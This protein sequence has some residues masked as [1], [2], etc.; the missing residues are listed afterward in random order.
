MNLNEAWEILAAETPPAQKQLSALRIVANVGIGVSAAVD[1]IGRRHLLLEVPSDE[2]LGDLTRIKGRRFSLGEIDQRHFSPGTKGVGLVLEDE[3]FRDLFAEL[4]RSVVSEVRGST[5]ARAAIPA[6]YNRVDRWRLFMERSR[7]KLSDAEVRGLIGEL[8]ILSRRVR[9][10]GGFAALESW[11][12]PSGSIRDFEAPDLSIEVKAYSGS[13]GGTVRI[14]DPLQ[15]VPDGTNTLLLA[16]VELVETSNDSD[17]LAAH[18]ERMS[19]LLAPSQVMQSRFDDMLA[20][21]GYVE[22]HSEYYQ[23]GYRV[24]EAKAFAVTSDFPRID[25]SM[26]SAAVRNVTFSML[27]SSLTQFAANIDSDIGPRGGE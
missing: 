21:Y 23:R 7:G 14:S 16:C 13:Q 1:L 17:T 22:E 8:E 20:S 18:I 2:S 11:K 19:H 6:I 4:C 25:P 3:S 24:A 5:S 10:A 9:Q 15:L 26:L 27:V 12:A